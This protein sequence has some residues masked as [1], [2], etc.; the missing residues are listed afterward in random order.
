M[1]K[2]PVSECLVNGKTSR[3]LWFSLGFY[4]EATGDGFPEG[5]YIRTAYS[6]VKLSASYQE[7]TSHSEVQ[8]IPCV[9]YNSIC[10][11]RTDRHYGREN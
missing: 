2:L 9:S 3:G 5:Y 7:M 8:M 1:T 4:S 6:C 10:R 11:E